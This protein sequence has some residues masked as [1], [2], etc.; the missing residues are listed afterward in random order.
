MLVSPVGCNISYYCVLVFTVAISHTTLQCLNVSAA[1][2]QQCP[3]DRMTNDMTNTALYMHNYYRGLLGTGW[4]EDR[5]RTYAPLAKVMPQLKYGCT[6]LAKKAAQ[7]AAACKE[8]PDPPSVATR[9]QNHLT[10]KNVDIK[11]EDALKQAISTW[12]EELA[13]IGVGDDTKYTDKNK[14]RLEH[15]ANMAYDQTKSVGCSVKTCTK[16]GLTVVVCQYDQKIDVDTNI[17]EVAKSGDKACSGCDANAV[18]MVI[19]F[20]TY[21]SLYCEGVEDIDIIS[22]GL[23]ISFGSTH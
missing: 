7:R 5:I 6:D 21:V 23:D 18:D 8:I 4:A 22:N 1:D 9:S 2:D 16:E 12:W 13:D 17:Y 11:P 3:D 20:P 10:I 14:N 15:F 19:C